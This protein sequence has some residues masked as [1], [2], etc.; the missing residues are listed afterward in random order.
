MLKSSM[1]DCDIPESHFSKA[2]LKCNQKN[3]IIKLEE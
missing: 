1:L 3:K 2:Q